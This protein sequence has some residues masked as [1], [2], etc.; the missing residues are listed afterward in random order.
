MTN[1]QFNLLFSLPDELIIEIFGTFD[2]TYRIFHTPEFRKEL[3]GA[4]WLN[5]NKK[6]VK[7]RIEEHFEEMTFND[8]ASF[9]NEYGYI[10]EVE[11]SQKQIK[12]LSFYDSEKKKKPTSYDERMINFEYDFKIYLHPAIGEYMFYKVLP[13]GA[14]KKK[15]AFLRNP[16][17]FDGFVGHEVT[18]K[19]EWA[20]DFCDTLAM[21]H[22]S[23]KDLYPVTEWSDGVVLFV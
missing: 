9:H 13:K 4:G 19:E 11:L 21:P 17:L 2:P 18:G 23:R 16:K 10:G 3:A 1:A 5:Q 20:N 12:K 8:N 14:T 15:W 22:L 6:S 7:S